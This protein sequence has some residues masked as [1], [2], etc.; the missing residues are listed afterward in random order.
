MQKGLENSKQKK[1]EVRPLVDVLPKEAKFP[2]SRL[3]RCGLGWK[4]REEKPA[5]KPSAPINKI[6]IVWT[7]A[8]IEAVQDILEWWEGGSFLNDEET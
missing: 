8:G 5:E 7:N 4:L 2:V 6:P 1:K 3:N